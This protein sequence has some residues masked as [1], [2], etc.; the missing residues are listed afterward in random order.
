MGVE[1]RNCSGGVYAS[2]LPTRVQERE[3]KPT[4]GID[5]HHACALPA[6]RSHPPFPSPSFISEDL[7]LLDYRRRAWLYYK[8]MAEEMGGTGGRSGMGTIKAERSERQDKK[9]PK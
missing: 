7:W 9:R 1:Q 4:C 8:V 6:C 2:H 5:R 3:I